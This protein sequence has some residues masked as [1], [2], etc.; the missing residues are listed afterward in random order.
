[1]STLNTRQHGIYITL[2]GITN[3]SV[4]TGCPNKKES[5]NSSEE[6][7]ESSAMS[8][9]LFTTFVLEKWANNG[10]CTERN[11][12]ECQSSFQIFK[13]GAKKREMLIFYIFCNRLPAFRFLKKKKT[14]SCFRWFFIVEV[15]LRLVTSKKETACVILLIGLAPSFCFYG[16]NHQLVQMDFLAQE[17]IIDERFLLI[18]SQCVQLL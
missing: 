3:V 17:S 8:T 4:C 1:M 16:V 11:G 9:L 15:K 12:S 5:T 6:K 10:P 2:Q 7:E 13:H 18:L 14:C